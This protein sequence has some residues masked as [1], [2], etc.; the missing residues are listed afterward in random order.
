MRTNRRWWVFFG[1][2]LFGCAG[3][4]IH[5]EVSSLA[6]PTAM[7]WK[8]Y[9]LLPGMKNV[10]AD[11]IQFAEYATILERALASRGLTR[12]SRFG[13]AQTV[14]FLRYGIGD[15]KTETYTYSV[16]VWGQTGIASSQTSGTVN[17]YGGYSATTTYTPSYGVTGY[18]TEMGSVT[19]Y[20]RWLSVNAVD[21]PTWQST[22]KLVDVWRTTVV[23]EGS[24]GDL[25]WVFGYLVAGA[26]PYIGTSTGKSVDVSLPQSSAEVRRLRGEK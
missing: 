11:D 9:F 4:Q 6:R 8:N 23:S 16:P 20:T 21:L 3:P 12:V 10:S 24:S 19:S 22:E 15:P 25:R 17:S 14:V 26:M 7:N 18:R 5:M 1:V 13:D 2:F